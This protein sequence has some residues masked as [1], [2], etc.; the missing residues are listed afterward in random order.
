MTNQGKLLNPI[1]IKTKDSSQI[2]QP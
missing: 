2:D 1:N